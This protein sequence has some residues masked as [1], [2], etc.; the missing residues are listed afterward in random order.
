MRELKR[1]LPRWFLRILAKKAFRENPLAE[2]SKFSRK[3]LLHLRNGYNRTLYIRLVAHTAIGAARLE[4]A[5]MLTKLAMHDYHLI[6]QAAAIRLIDL[7]GEEGIRTLQSGITEAVE[8][9]QTESLA[10]AIRHAEIHKFELA[11]LW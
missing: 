1:K 7:V 5:D 3:D 4:D 6:A 10:L 11:R 8:V 2:E 9:G